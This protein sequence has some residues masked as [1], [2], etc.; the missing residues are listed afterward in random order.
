MSE[1]RGVPDAEY[2]LRVK[3]KGIDLRVMCQVN[4]QEGHK[5]EERGIPDAVS[6]LQ[7]SQNQKG[8][9]QL[10]HQEMRK[11]YSLSQQ[12]VSG[13][14]CCPKLRGTRGE[15]CPHEVCTVVFRENKRVARFQEK[16]KHGTSVQRYRNYQSQ[17]EKFGKDVRCSQNGQRRL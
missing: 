8:K 16:K 1:E 11:D 14:R 6:L 7:R 5:T 4:P 10:V 12:E 9:A 15:K 3:K 17:E 13:S 2:Q